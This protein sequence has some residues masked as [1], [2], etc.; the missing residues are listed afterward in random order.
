MAAA[1]ELPRRAL[2]GWASGEEMHEE[3]LAGLQRRR[4]AARAAFDA[5]EKGPARRAAREA[6]D[7]VRAEIQAHKD[8]HQRG[9]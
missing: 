9:A 2:R 5:A 8:Q 6:L 3:A 1:S 7:K 4:V